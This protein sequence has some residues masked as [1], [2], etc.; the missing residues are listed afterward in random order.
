VSAFSVNNAVVLFQ[1]FPLTAILLLL[2]LIARFYQ[3]FSQK[4]MFYRL[5]VFVILAFGVATVRYAGVD[6]L[7]GDRVGDVFYAIGGI[8]LVMLCLRLYFLMCIQSVK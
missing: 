1:W 5:F 6:S 3:R 8:T 2:L 4:R 7:S